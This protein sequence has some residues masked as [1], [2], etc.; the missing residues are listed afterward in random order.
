MHVNPRSSTWPP[1][2]GFT[3]IEVLVALAVLAVGLLGLASLMIS[4]L[5]VTRSALQYTLA[6][7]LLNDMA[8]H[9]RA[10]RPGAAAYA[11]TAGTELDAPAASCAT[12]GECSPTLLAA[13]DLYRWQSAARAALPETQTS[14][15]VTTD[16]SGAQTC[17]ITLQW[18]QS[19]DAVPATATVTVQ[20]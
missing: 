17:A 13:L 16:A 20:V 8:D 15:A 10:N 19:G 1:G 11:L 7:A 4:G 6:T 9:I 3:L 18:R 5:Q 14:I 2:D 12:P